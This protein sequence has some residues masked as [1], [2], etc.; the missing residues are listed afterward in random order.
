MGV[1]VP[2]GPPVAAGVVVPVFVLG[3][4]GVYPAW[5]DGDVFEVG[6][7]E[8]CVGWF[9]GVCFGVSGFVGGEEVEVVGVDVGLADSA[10]VDVFV[11]VEGEVEGG[12]EL[13]CG[14]WVSGAVEAVDAMLVEVGAG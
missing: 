8:G 1:E 5:G 11:G 10:Q 6:E 9:V 14:V 3:V 4:G 13:G 7:G 2:G 12:L